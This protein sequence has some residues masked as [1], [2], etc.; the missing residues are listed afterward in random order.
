MLTKFYLVQK[1]G[2][3][4]IWQTAPDKMD[5]LLRHQSGYQV[6]SDAPC[7]TRAEALVRLRKLF[8]GSRPVRSR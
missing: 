3:P 2:V 7:D 5:R 1:N 8:P 4:A 6:T